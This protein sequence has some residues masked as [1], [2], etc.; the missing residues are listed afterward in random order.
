MNRDGKTF[1]DW[2]AVE[3]VDLSQ[4]W[5]IQWRRPN[6]REPYIGLRNWICPDCQQAMH[7]AVAEVELTRRN[8]ASV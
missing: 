7:E 6:A 4:L 5:E 8:G 3:V 2:C 1:C